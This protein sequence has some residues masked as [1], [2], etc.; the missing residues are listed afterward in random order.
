MIY[1]HFHCAVKNTIFSCSRLC[2]PPQLPYSHCL[3]FNSCLV[4]VKISAQRPVNLGMV[5]SSIL[6]PCPL[7]L[8]SLWDEAERQHLSTRDMCPHN[9]T[10]A[11]EAGGTEWLRFTSKMERN[12]ICSR[13]SSTS[14]PWTAAS[15]LSCFVF[16]FICTTGLSFFA[17][18]S[19]RGCLKIQL[20]WVARLRKCSWL[21]TNSVCAA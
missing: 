6:S 8:A 17:V 14:F 3:Y 2:L 18:Q 20:P 5:C 21:K 15:I 12:Y 9:L 19:P 7:C 1:W 11:A 10:K 4:L 13:T 16:V